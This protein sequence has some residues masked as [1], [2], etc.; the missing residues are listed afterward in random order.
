MKL[1]PID[2]ESKFAC[3][4]LCRSAFTLIE[5][6]VVIAIIGI[7]VALV[8]PAVQ[9]A[10]EAAR[11]IRCANNLKQLGLASH[12]FHDVHGAF[13]PARLILDVPRVRNDS[14]TLAGMDEPTWLV[15]LLPFVEQE[16]LHSMWDEYQPY[17]RNPV[18]ARNQALSL[19]LCPSRRSIDKASVQDQTIQIVSACGCP[20]G[21]QIVP[22]GAVSDYVANHGDLSP[23]AVNLPSDFYWGGNGTG[24]IIS[25]RPMGNDQRLGRG[26]ID[27]VKLADIIDG[28]SNTLLIGESHIPRGQ[29]LTTPYNGPAYYG[30][31]LTNFC[32][33]G[34]PGVPLAHSPDD[35][36]ANVFSFGSAHPNIV[37]FA[38][39]DGSLRTVSTA[40]STRSLGRLTNRKDGE[41]IEEVF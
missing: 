35:Q 4:R 5:L 36:R 38:F 23:G 17:G 14:A 7:I 15:R 19:F 10:R 9:N 27:K 11:R 18:N 28:S 33:I 22:G 29:D 1:R 24:V 2:R 37:Q 20:S 16:T 26:W 31:Y 40:I 8:L 41:A 12:M 32:R 30:R 25:S 13:P 34:G 39:A 3:S 21:I 6:L